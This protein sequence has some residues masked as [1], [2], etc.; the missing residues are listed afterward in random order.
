VIG[1]TPNDEQAII[2][3]SLTKLFVGELVETGKCHDFA[4]INS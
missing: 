1:K 2:C 4:R 3:A